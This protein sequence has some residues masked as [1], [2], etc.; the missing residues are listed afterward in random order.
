MRKS[1]TLTPDQRQARRELIQRTKPW[2]RST[3]PKTTEGKAKAAQ[4][5]RRHGMRAAEIKVIKVW[6][7]SVLKL[8]E[9]LKMSESA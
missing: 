4:R 7:L 5:W 3:G 9:V 6:T 8:V 2:L 1:P